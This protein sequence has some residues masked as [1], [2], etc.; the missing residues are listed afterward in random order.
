M[1]IQLQYIPFIFSGR[2]DMYMAQQPD[3]FFYFHFY[4]QITYQS[5]LQNTFLNSQ[6]MSSLD[7]LKQLCQLTNNKLIN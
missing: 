2:L 7:W 1:N 4:N 6:T 3:L 5:I